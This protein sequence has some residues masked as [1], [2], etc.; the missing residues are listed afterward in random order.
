MRVT[1]SDRNILVNLLTHLGRKQVKAFS[2]Y[3]K[4]PMLLGLSM[5]GEKFRDYN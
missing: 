3:T 2:C 5:G 4:I 1:L